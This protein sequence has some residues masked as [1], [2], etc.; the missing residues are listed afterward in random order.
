MACRDPDIL[1]LQEQLRQA[2]ACSGPFRPGRDIVS[3]ISAAL[4]AA[5]AIYARQRGAI[6]ATCTRLG[7]DEDTRHEAIRVATGGRTASLTE[8]SQLERSAILT[9]LAKAQGIRKPRP[10]GRDRIRPP[11]TLEAIQRAIRA[12]LDTAGRGDEYADAIARTRLGVD[13]WEWLDYDGAVKLHQMLEIDQRRRVAR[14]E[15]VA[16]V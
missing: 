9:G 10:R 3:E 8:T 6:M 14:R 11:R 2:R 16:A 15:Q 4:A 7:I 1:R 13:A 12:L 5:K